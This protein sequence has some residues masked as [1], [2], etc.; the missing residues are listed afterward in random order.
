MNRL[1]ATPRR[2][3][4]VSALAAVAVVVAAGFG[5]A[6]VAA[7]NQTYTGC[8]QSGALTNIAIGETPF[9]ACPKNATQVSWSQPA[10]RVSGGCKASPARKAREATRAIPA[11]KGCGASSDY[12][13][14]KASL[15]RPGRR[16]SPPSQA[17]NAS[18]RTASRETSS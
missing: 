2:V 9:K 17:P 14:S 13:V 18:A 8:L 16:P 5:Y 10:R 11:C 7:E 3:L 15:D 6:A 1:L 12:L 4:A